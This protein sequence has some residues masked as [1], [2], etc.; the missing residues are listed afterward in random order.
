MKTSTVST[1][2]YSH[3]GWGTG[4]ADVNEMRG[5]GPCSGY[6][7]VTRAL[8]VRRGYLTKEWV[9]NFQTMKVQMNRIEIG[10]WLN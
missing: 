1:S 3:R 10:R 5:V 6:F 9:F 8:K 4:V 7:K 2:K